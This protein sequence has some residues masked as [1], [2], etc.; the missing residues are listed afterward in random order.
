MKKN[1][2]LNKFKR[3]LIAIMC[4]ITLFFSMPVKSRA[5]AGIL[6]SIASFIMLIPDGVQ[7]LLNRYVSD[8]TEDVKFWLRVDVPDRDAGLFAN[9]NGTLYNF[10]VTPYDIFTAGTHT[11]YGEYVEYYNDYERAQDKI[12]Q[13]KQA[14]EAGGGSA[15]EWV[16]HVHEGTDAAN[17]VNE[18]YDISSFTTKSL[19]K[20]PL[21]DANF[22]RKDTGDSRNSADILRPIIS[23]VYKNLRNFVLILMLVILLYIG[24][25]IIISSAV[26]EQVKYKQYIRDWVV[27]IC[28][29][30]LMQYIMSAIMNINENVNN[31]LIT[32]R[33]EQTYTIAFGTTDTTV[34]KIYRTFAKADKAVTTAFTV[35]VQGILSHTDV[36]TEI[37]QTVRRQAGARWNYKADKRNREK[38]DGWDK[39]YNSDNK[40]ERNFATRKLEI[41]SAGQTFEEGKQNN[42]LGDN[43]DSEITLNAAVYDKNS[44][45]GFRAIYY[46]NI[47]EYCRTLTTFS[48]KYTHIFNNNK[49]TTM[50]EASEDDDLKGENDYASAAYWGYAFLYIILTFE[51]VI[52]LYKYMKRVLWLAFLTMIAPLIALMY[53][54]DKVGDG[55]AQTFNMWFKEYLFNTLIQPL[56]ILLYTIFITVSSQ[57]ITTNV[58]Y[59]IVAYAFM[60]TAEK[61]FKKMFGFDKASTPGGLGSPAAGMMAMRGLDKLGGWGPHGKGGKDGKSDS[62]SSTSKIKYAKNPLATPLE[63]SV[64]PV[65][66]GGNARQMGGNV[67]QTG[68]RIPP[69]SGGLNI[70]NNNVA[71]LSN[72]GNS[73]R[74]GRAKNWL[75]N[76]GKV[77]KRNG[78]DRL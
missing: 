3:I 35:G 72:G 21:L 69:S 50:S 78:Y 59:G 49:E 20:M 42:V 56:H 44:T 1:K 16:Q 7:Y 14:I 24:I 61:F 39:L 13:D 57:L 2:I 43:S 52:F 58:I 54:V 32:N 11:A 51:T 76:R 23:N 4:I 60:L 29:V 41:A 30:F 22:F 47:V 17:A 48:T 71:P 18:T 9:N 10:E 15:T 77:L 75:N 31:M 64:N 65:G 34:S 8:E 46:C 28:L 62:S 67:R 26:S 53:P 27:G 45:N 70:N 6:E 12:E 5:D 19:V 55:K 63:G 25:R 40:S 73:A 38:G 68:G 37:L 33:E 36:G 74:G 66:A